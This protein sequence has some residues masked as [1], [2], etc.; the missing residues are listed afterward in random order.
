MAKYVVAVSGGVDSVVLLD[1]L[2]QSNHTI[3]VAHVD[4]GIRGEDSA[5][6]ARFVAALAKRYNVPFVSTALHLGNSASE[7]RARNGRYDF[8][9]TQA[10]KLGAQ[11]VTAHH[12]GD[13]VETIA[14]NFTRGTG[15]RGLAVLARNEIKRPLL[16]FTKQQLY[17]YALCHKL[18]WVEDATNHETRYLRNKLRKRIGA[19]HVDTRA[20]LSLRARQ[21]QLCH[22]IDGEI[23]KLTQRQAG[24]RHFLTMLDEALAIEVLRHSIWQETGKYLQRPQLRRAC[25][26]VRV[27]AAGT[28]HRVGENVSLVFTARNYHVTVV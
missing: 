4:H 1:M 19:A 21:L 25:H 13:V 20:L 11:V 2:A 9:F 3:V 24:S 18:E 15:W 26:A 12:A 6:D 22:D 14:L 5:A 16:A 10:E 8:L 23:A 27:A 7:E 28:T 17:D